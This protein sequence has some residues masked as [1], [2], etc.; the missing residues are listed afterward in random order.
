MSLKEFAALSET[1]LMARTAWAEARDQGYIGIL[2]VCHVV[3]NRFNDGRFGKT[4]KGTMLKKWAFS[5]FNSNDPQLPILSEGPEGDL[6]LI[7]RTIAGLALAG[8]T[9]D[10][11]SGA[12]HYYAPKLVNPFKT[13][14][15][16]RDPMKF[17]IVIGDH[18]FFRELN[19][20]SKEESHA[21]ENTQQGQLDLVIDGDVFDG[22]V[23]D[24]GVPDVHAPTPVSVDNIRSPG[25]GPHG[26][27]EVGGTET[28]ELE[29]SVRQ[30][31]RK[32]RKPRG[33]R[34]SRK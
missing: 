33:Q 27:Q 6:I 13:G 25:D 28:S 14:A 16:K 30:S 3:I 12:T 22:I 29:H 34:H 15:W 19:H 9:L 2:A 17:C 4:L 23:H 18:M 11:T 20:N 24:G 32:P 1:E 5:C 26:V 10:P 31:G 8:F 7:C 21:V